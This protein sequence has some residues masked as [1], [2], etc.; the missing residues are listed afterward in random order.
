M[1][2][3]LEEVMSHSYAQLEEQRRLQAD[4]SLLKTYLVEAHVAERSHDAALHLIEAAFASERVGTGSTSD[5]IE[6]D[7]PYFFNISVRRRDQTTTFYLDASDRRFWIVHS[8]DKST[9]TDNLLRRII[10]RDSRFDFAWLPMQL[11]E[12]I[13]HLGSFRGLGLDYDR[14]KIPDVD[15]DA[16]GAPV[17]FLKM[18][19]WGNRAADVLRM[20]RQEANFPSATTLS[21]VKVKHWLDRQRDEGLFSLD[22]VKYDGKITA[23]GTS[24][25]SHL[26]LVTSVYRAYAGK[27]RE[28]EE[29]FAI[30]YSTTERNRL[31]VKG[32]PFNFKFGRP[33]GNLDIFVKTVF[34][35]SHPFRLWGVPKRIRDN[36]F[37]VTAVDLHVSQRVNF[38]ISPTFMRVYLPAGSC[39]NTIARLYTNLQH[40]YDSLIESNSGNGESTFEF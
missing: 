38:E 18:Q 23:R 27:I 17:E 40:Y 34:A 1:A 37:R 28:F 35:S 20:L 2:Q 4:S 15:F 7:E 30:E 29:R 39:G 24:F 33:I 21:K 32:E 9:P 10:T 26:S 25:Q 11:L 6:T 8:V 16:P 31:V 19:L 5:V 14:R 22:D 12:N 3:A 13:T 36:F